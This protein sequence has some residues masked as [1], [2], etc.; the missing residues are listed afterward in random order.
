MTIWEEQDIESIAE[1]PLDW[2]RLKN[3]VIMISGGTGFIGTFLTDVFRYRNNNYNDNIS[4]ISLSRRGGNSDDTMKCLKADIRNEITYSDGVD[5]VLHLASNTQPKL[6]ALD[7]IGTI[8]TNVIGCDNLLKFSVEKKV[9]RFLLASSVEIYGQGQRAPVDEMYSGYID[10]NNARSGYNEAKRTCEA[11]C[12]AYRQQYSMETVA[13]RLAR[14]FGAD[15]KEDTKAMSQL[16]DKAVAG[17]DIILKSKGNQRYS[18]CY[19]ADVA[20]AIIK[21]LLDGVDGEVYNVAEDDEGLTLGEYAEY[22]ANLAGKKVV[23][24]IEE[25]ASVSKATFALLSSNKLKNIG[26]N[27]IYTV[28]EALKRTY[29]IKKGS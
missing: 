14:V 26:W 2:K 21:V 29:E 12:Q 22:L 17:E 28:S 19:I 6:Y 7:P 3:K 4:V 27:P 8:M 1:F 15:K 20:S 24:K 23:Y 16:I 13:V 18:F 9:K 25:N 11:L 10:C 5:Y